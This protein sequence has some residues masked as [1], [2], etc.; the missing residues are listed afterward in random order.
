MNKDLVFLCWYL[1]AYLQVPLQGSLPSLVLVL[2]KY[3]LI[4]WA[5]WELRADSLTAPIEVLVC[6]IAAIQ[7]MLE[8]PVN[9]PPPH[10]LHVRNALS[11][12]LNY[13]IYPVNT[14]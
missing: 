7:K 11:I 1:A 6:M 10:H 5:V 9:L 3:S 8:L 14:F 4:M 2:V 12:P 13:L